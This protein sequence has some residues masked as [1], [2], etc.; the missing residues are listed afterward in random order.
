MSTTPIFWQRSG[1]PRLFKLIISP[2]F[3]ERVDLERLTWQLLKS[4]EKD[5][6]C[7]FEWIATIHNNTEHRHVHVALRY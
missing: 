1:D 5:F 7:R 2:E 3:G 4:M 6:G